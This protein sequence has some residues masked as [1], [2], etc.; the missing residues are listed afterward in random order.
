MSY[1]TSVMYSS[2]TRLARPPRLL[3]KASRLPSH[4]P[5]TFLL[6]AR[7]MATHS[8]TLLEAVADDHQ[9]MYTYYDQYLKNAGNNEAQERWARQFTWEVARH[10]VGEEL[11]VYPLMEQHLGAQG[12]QLADKDREDHQ[13]VKELLYQLESIA[14]GS[15]EHASLLKSVMERLRPHNDSEEK[16]DLPLLMK[17]L[18]AE[19]S[20]H[21]VTSFKRTKKF[22]PTRTH[23]GAPDKPP[24]ETLAGLLAAPVDKLKDM[25]AQF[26]TQE[27]KE[28]AVKN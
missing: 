17:A 25:F 19:D 7:A 13:K 11:V 8:M 24:F 26:P 4:R 6:A 22:A 28:A 5:P 23:P 16:T 20:A 18:S 9:E 15:Q 1:T 27:E 12:K 10:A 3:F 14:P 2:L 21:A